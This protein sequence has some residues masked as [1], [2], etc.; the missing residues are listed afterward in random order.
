MLSDVRNKNKTEIDFITGKI[1]S[2]ADELEIKVPHNKE[3]YKEIL[4]IEQSYTE[5]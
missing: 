4:A 1:V 5:L 3:I 2:Y